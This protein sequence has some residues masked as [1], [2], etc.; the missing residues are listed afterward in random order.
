MPLVQGDHPPGGVE[1]VDGRGVAAV[2]VADRVGEHGA[3]AGPAGHP[4]HPPGVRGG[5]GTP[6][7]AAGEPVGHELDEEVLGGHQLP[8]RRNGRVGQVVATPGH[9]RAQLGGGAEQDNQVAVAERAGEL[10]GQEPE[11]E[12][13]VPPLTGQVG[14]R[15]QAAQRRPAGPPA[16]G[17]ERHPRQP[18][19]AE[20]AA[21]HRG[22]G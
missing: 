11:V 18:E 15:D 21:A 5:A 10:L 20:R 2:G 13:R 12:H 8:P 7:R 14:R 9:G 22:P 3:E 6:D 17:Q 16:G 4:G 1:D 19:I